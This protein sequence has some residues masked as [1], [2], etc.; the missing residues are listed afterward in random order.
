[1]TLPPPAVLPSLLA[2][3]LLL[4]VAALPANTYTDGQDDTA[5]YDTSG[6][7]DGLIL[8]IEEGTATQ[9]GILS[10]DGYVA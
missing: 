10:G 3:A 7:E 2:C 9:S 1:M 8:S 4:P 5:T 6:L